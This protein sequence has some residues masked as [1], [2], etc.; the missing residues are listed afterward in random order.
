MIRYPIVVRAIPS[1]RKISF[2]DFPGCCFTLRPK[3]G[4]FETEDEFRAAIQSKALDWPIGNTEVPGWIPTRLKGGYTIFRPETYQYHLLDSEIELWTDPL[5]ENYET[6]LEFHWTRFDLRQTRD[7]MA[8]LMAIGVN[9]L[10]ALEEGLMR[11]N[12]RDRVMLKH[13]LQSSHTRLKPGISIPE[14]EVEEIAS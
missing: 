10:A 11:P 6:G 3:P 9:R 13:A 14:D 8:R 4:E 12:H 2:P 7:D 5:P 1:G